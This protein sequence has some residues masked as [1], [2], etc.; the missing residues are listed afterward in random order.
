MRRQLLLGE[1]LSVCLLAEQSL[2]TRH[3]A[4][5]GILTENC[6]EDQT[7]A[8]DGAHHDEAEG[9]GPHRLGHLP[10]G[11]GQCCVVYRRKVSSEFIIDEG[12]EKV[13]LTLT[14]L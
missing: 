10:L 1:H 14:F 3:R 11:L 12:R 5:P 2:D 9:H 4:S 6:P 13:Q 7:V 8:Q